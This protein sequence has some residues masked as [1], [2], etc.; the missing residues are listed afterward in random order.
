M[1][2][3]MTKISELQAHWYESRKGLDG[4]L[5]EKLYPLLKSSDKALVRQSIELL[6]GF[7]EDAFCEVLEEKG[8]ELV[9]RQDLGIK[10]RLLWEQNIISFVFNPT[11]IWHELYLS[12]VFWGMLF[13][14]LGKSTWDELDERFQGYVVEESL[15]KVEIPPGTFWM[16]A[17][18]DDADAEETEKNSHEV[19]ITKKLEVCIYPVTQGLYESVMGK[20]PSQMA[21]VSR[22]VTDISW[23]DALVFCN[24]LS[25]KEGLE[26]VYILPEPFENDDE[27]SQ[28]VIYNQQA[29]GYRLPTEAEWEYA[30][31]GGEYHLFSGSDDPDEVAWYQENSNQRSHPVGAKKPNAFG[32]YDMSG[33]V[34]EMCWD[35]FDRNAYQRGASIDP[36]VEDVHPRRVSRG[37]FCWEI[38]KALRVSCRTGS[39]PSST[40]FGRGFRMLKG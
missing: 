10:H 26:K 3:S 37:G 29:N 25:E 17:L 11:S 5:D 12:G 8:D 2:V 33:N 27:W 31:R 14:L 6:V 23:C 24:R 40:L 20:N 7:G 16:G 1:A 32:L 9:L 28:K 34:L 15:Q 39:K 22:P 30:A 21:G 19:Q 13:R 36:L 18:P 35:F 4:L 38:R